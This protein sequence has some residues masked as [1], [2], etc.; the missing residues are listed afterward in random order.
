VPLSAAGGAAAGLA[1]GSRVDVVAST[2]EGAAGRSAVVVADAEVLAVS[3]EAATAG[4]EMPTGSALLRV[5]SRAALR[6]TSALNFARDVRL[7]VRPAGERPGAAAGSPP[8]P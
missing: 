7:L 1:P 3:A 6:L 4:V 8:P 2:G 5:S